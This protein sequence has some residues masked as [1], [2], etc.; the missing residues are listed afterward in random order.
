MEDLKIENFDVGYDHLVLLKNSTLSLARGR[1]YGLVAANGLG[2]S[3]LLRKMAKRE[4]EFKVIPEYIDMWYVEQEVEGNDTPCLEFVINCD[5]ERLALMKEEDELLNAEE[6]DEAGQERLQQITERLEEKEAYNA[7][8]RARK[9]L[10]GLQ[11]EPYMLEQPTKHFSGGWRMRI[12]F[13]CALFCR[14]QLMLLDEPTNHLDLYAC[15]WL[16]NYL[17]QWKN[18]L[19][20]VSHDQDFLNNVCTDIIHLREQQLFYYR[21]KGDTDRQS[22]DH[23]KHLYREELRVMWK[24]YEKDLKAY[25]TQKAKSGTVKVDNNKKSNATKIAEQKKKGRGNEP[26]ANKGKG[27]RG[28]GDDDFPTDE[29]SPPDQPP[30]EY[31]VEF[32]FPDPEQLVWPVIKLYEVGFGYKEGTENR[33]FTGLEF[34]LG[35]DTRIAL[36]GRNGAGKTTLLKVMTGELEPT[37]GNVESNRHLIVGR[38]NQHFMDKLDGRL[39]PIQQIQKEFGGVDEVPD[40]EARAMLGRFNLDGRAHTR[41]IDTL[42]GGQKSRVALAL[43]CFKHPHILFFDEP[44]NH[45]DIESIQALVAAIKDFKGG[46]ILVSHDQ[47][48]IR[49]TCETIMVVG[50][51]EAVEYDGEFDE[52][53]E[54]LL[55]QFLL[56]EEEEE[57]IAQAAQKQKAAEREAKRKAL[58]ERKKKP[59]E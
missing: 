37:E 6:V 28:K 3:T 54:E 39:T 2:K 13:A 32:H 51:G 4:D 22:Y 50:D 56:A 17:K 14:P 40:K 36:V 55:E 5:T 45:L 11:F 44:T 16:E 21:P 1:K 59:A 12:A 24:N 31:N 52:Y 58:A 25:K 29:I 34:G 47:R 26:V 9:I 35:M 53:K 38:F 48:L 49:E 7:E 20:I 57:R 43:I 27:K 30:K 41:P 8:G 18:T 15:I 19:L 42:S 10:R 23:F 46:L 33:L